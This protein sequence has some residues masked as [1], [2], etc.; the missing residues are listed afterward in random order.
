MAMQAEDILYIDNHLIAVNK[1]P[2][3]ISQ[4]DKTG[5]PSLLETVKEYLKV[6]YNKPGNVYLGLVHRIDRPVSGVLLFAR[7]SK[8]AER[9]SAMIRDRQFKKIYWAVVKNRPAEEAA[10]LE[11]YLIKNQH[12]NK[13]YVTGAGKPDA[14]KASLSY[15]LVRS[16]ERYHLLE[17]E[18]HTGRHHQIRTQLA[19]IGCPI[20]G[21]IKYGFDRSN[22]DGSIHL[23]ARSITFE[24]PV[25]HATIT[26]V[27]DPP[28][29][30]IWD[31][32]SR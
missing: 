1:K 10:T 3:E 30:P 29:D 18:L 26:I 14:R 5:D 17:I 24:H 27:A 15:Q 28:K 2:G 7:T 4:G 11:H 31:A 25:T 22:P 12:Q 6:T 32:C 20:R 8:A 23:H 13:S 9:M 19:A 16:L 21:D